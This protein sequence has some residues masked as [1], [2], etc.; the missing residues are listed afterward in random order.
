MNRFIATLLLV[1]LPAGFFPASGSA[2]DRTD[3]AQVLIRGTVRFVS[4][5]NTYGI[6]DSDGKRYHPARKL[7]REFQHDGL[8]VVV[9]ARLRPDLF[10]PRMY[11]PA[12]EIRKIAKADA[13]VAEDEREAIRLLLARMNAFNARDLAQ[14]KKL[15][16]VARALSDEQFA[17]WASGYGNY[18]LHYVELDGPGTVRLPFDSL[19]GVCLYSRERV[20]SMALS[21]NVEYTVSRFTLSKLDG[22]WKFVAIAPFEPED[23]TDMDQ[24]VKNYLDLARQRYG[25]ID[26][27]QWKG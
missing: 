11:G 16:V 10:G 23:G 13:Y 5:S 1:L 3:A 22:E 6:M 25:T 19:E 20:N 8:A 24:V 21:G 2:A 27:A 14:L 7:T 17:G 18:T 12:I 4:S 26:L 9:D 15:D